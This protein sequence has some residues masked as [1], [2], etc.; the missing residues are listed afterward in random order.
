MA[1]LEVRG[2]SK[3]FGGVS[4]LNEVSFDLYEGTVTALVGPNGAGKTTLFNVITGFVR[5]D[6]GEIRFRGRNISFL[7]PHEIVR[8]GIVRTFQNLRLFQSMTVWENI[9]IALD[10]MQGNTKKAYEIACFLGI[11]DLINERVSNLSYGE[12]KLVSLART[13]ATG[14]TL[15]LLDELMAG[16]DENWL[17]RILG[18]VK[19]LRDNRKTICLIEHN[20]NVVRSVASQIIFMSEGR[21]LREGNAEDIL[22][23]RELQSV[24]LGT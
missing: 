3:R 18:V 13:M 2:V 11:G 6:S 24:Y 4:A 23:D 15:F 17:R 21:V 12:Q 5:P 19:R 14:G 7:P 8:C 22:G 9:V 20:L 1:L 10:H 16:L